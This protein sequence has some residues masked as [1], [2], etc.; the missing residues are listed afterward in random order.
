M[1]PSP[2]TGVPSSLVPLAGN[3][4]NSDCQ[5]QLPLCQGLEGRKLVT[6]TTAD[7]GRYEVRHLAHVSTHSKDGK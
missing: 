6:L 5:T 3:R 7:S 2:P 4:T 1:T